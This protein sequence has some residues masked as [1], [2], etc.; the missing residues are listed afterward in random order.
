VRSLNIFCASADT[1]SVMVARRISERTGPI[2]REPT[3]DKV[4]VYL[5]LRGTVM[6]LLQAN[7]VLKDREPYVLIAQTIRRPS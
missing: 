6:P 5:P 4:L 7:A 3:R 1:N 2:K